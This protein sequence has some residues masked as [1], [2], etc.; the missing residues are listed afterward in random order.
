MSIGRICSRS[1]DVID[2]NESVCEA[3]R[4][5]REREVG[6]LV[7]IDETRRPVGILTARD[8]VGR[9][10]ADGRAA[11]AM[12]VRAVMTSNPK[13][14]AE[15]API[16][17]AASAMMFGSVRRLPVVDRGGKVVGMITLDDVTALLAEEFTIIGKL[18]ESQM[19]HRHHGLEAALAH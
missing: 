3:A 5:M 17:S 1:V 2:Q 18:L 9:V 15:E 4:H 8:L 16:E 19:S 14:I 10:L 12:R 6:M 11:S 13:T 7:A